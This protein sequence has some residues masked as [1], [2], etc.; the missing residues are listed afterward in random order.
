MKLSNQIQ[1]DYTFCFFHF[2][3]ELYGKQQSIFSEISLIKVHPKKVFITDEFWPQLPAE[4]INK[5]HYFHNGWR[6]SRAS[7]PNTR[8]D[9]EP[10]A[11]EFSAW[12]AEAADLWPINRACGA[13]FIKRQT[14]AGLGARASEA[15]E[16]RRAR[17]QQFM[18][19]SKRRLLN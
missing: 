7:I 13:H 6:R 19:V 3:T 9:A 12:D 10:A 8:Q 11:N 15:S 5:I 4:K 2:H 18:Q 14:H 1:T 16:C 17:I